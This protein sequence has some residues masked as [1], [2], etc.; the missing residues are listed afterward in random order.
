MLV[1]RTATPLH[2]L[3]FCCLSLPFDCSFPK[4]STLTHF[5]PRESCLCWAK[6]GLGRPEERVQVWGRH[7][8]QS[9]A[10]GGEG[11]IR[12]YINFLVRLLP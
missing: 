6:P 12:S 2:L 3:D 8:G 5:I 11:G 10:E 9:Y 1:K 4:A 7:W